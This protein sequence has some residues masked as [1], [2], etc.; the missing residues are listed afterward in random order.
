MSKRPQLYAGMAALFAAMPLAASDDNHFSV[1]LRLQPEL[2]QVSGSAADSRDR[3]GWHLTDGWGGGNKN[4][5]N[6]GALFIDGGFR[7]GEQTRVVGRLGFNLD[8]GGLK[9]GDARQREVEAGLEGP[10][11]RLVVGRLETPYKI[12]GLGWDPLNATFMQARANLGRSGG[13][14]GHGG[15]IDNA[16]SYSH[17]VGDL[18][19]TLFGAVDDLSDL[20]SGGTSGNHAWSLAVN[21]PLGPVEM[22]AAHIDASEFKQGPDKRTGTKLGLRWSHEAWTL[23]SHWERRGSGLENGDFFHLNAS[24]RLDDAWQ[25]MAGAS[26]FSD[27]EADNDGNY[28]ALAVRYHVDRRFSIHGGLRRNDRDSI[29]SETIAGI[30]MRIIL[31]TGNLLAGDSRP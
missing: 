9:D 15:Y 16:L 25:I 4:S 24:Y 5:H 11:G 19:F 3:T 30:G 17:A 1:L 10:W 6:W 20:G 27:G 21:L 23:A 26:L 29:G 7:L 8:M 14:F 28:A 12:A 22:I 18:R 2:V 13:A 31:A